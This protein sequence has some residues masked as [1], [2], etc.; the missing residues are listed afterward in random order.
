[1]IGRILAGKYHIQSL[2]GEGA[3]GRVYQAAHVDGGEPAAIKVLHQHL[4]LDPRVAKRFHREARTASR[5]VHPNSVEIHGYGEDDDGTLYIAMELLPGRDMLT[6]IENEGP[7]PPSRV[8]RLLSDSLMALGA[9]HDHG[10]VHRDFKPE[11]VLISTTEGGEDHVKVCDFGIA[12]I[13]EA[14]GGSAIT[15][16][17]FVCGTPEYMAPEQARGE[18]IDVRT[19]I[20]AAGCMLYQLLTGDVPF[21]GDTPLGIITQH[22]TDFAVPATKHRPERKI[23]VGLSRIAERAM[24]KEARYRYPTAESMHSALQRVAACLGASADLEPGLMVDDPSGDINVAPIG[25]PKLPRRVRRGKGRGLVSNATLA[26]LILLVGIGLGALLMLTPKEGMSGLVTSQSQSPAE[27]QR[28]STPTPE[29][30]PANNVDAE[31]PQAPVTAPPAPIASPL[32]SDASPAPNVTSSRQRT[33]RREPAPSAPVPP[34]AQVPPAS[35]AQ[36]PA[37]TSPYDEGRRLFLA[38]DL[39]GAIRN[40]EAAAR[41]SPGSARVHKQLGRAYMR[42]GQ[43]AAGQ[44]AYR[45]YLE[46]A[47]NAADRPIIERLIGQ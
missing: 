11:N 10:I 9:A 2:L 12:K 16:S 19:D 29:P 5:F 17:G 27:R 45:R 41:Q 13:A 23:P 42:S 25:A 36:E 32:T 28:T 40:F 22:L 46:L 18:E 34:E 47:P 14:D 38:N 4:A 24:A 21:S 43:L 39:S 20:Y 7:F 8:I 44:R 35:P 1:V 33:R 31:G 3:M 30:S 37:Q 15:V 6:L 26:I